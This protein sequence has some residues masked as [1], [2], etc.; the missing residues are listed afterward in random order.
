MS[1]RASGAPLWSAL[2]QIFRLGS[3]FSTFFDSGT[4]F[5][6]FFKK[7]VNFDQKNTSLPNLEPWIVPDTTQIIQNLHEKQKQTH[8]ISG[9]LPRSAKFNVFSQTVTSFK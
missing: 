1:R 4:V 3:F 5:R 7:F 6:V 8:K 2:G 9:C